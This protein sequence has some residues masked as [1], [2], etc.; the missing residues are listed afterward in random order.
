MHQQ[1]MQKTLFRKTR[2]MMKISEVRTS[3]EK[4]KISLT[5]QLTRFRKSENVFSVMMHRYQNNRNMSWRISNHDQRSQSRICIRNSR[6]QRIQETHEKKIA[7]C[8]SL[9]YFV[10]KKFSV[11]FK[12]SQKHNEK[13]LRNT[14][15][16]QTEEQSIELIVNIRKR[17]IWILIDS[18]SDISYMNSQLQ[19]NLEIK[20][21]E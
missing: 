1:S 10:S 20:K 19:K 4:K 2:S 7:R 5:Y 12:R 6:I 9:C 3:C 21:K 11:I 18:A 14:K 13:W 8:D 17:K 16:Q 15:N